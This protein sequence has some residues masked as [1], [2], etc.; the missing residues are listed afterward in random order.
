MHTP[1]PLMIESDSAW[2][3]RSI[4]KNE[5]VMFSESTKGDS[6]AFQLYVGDKEKR[7]ALYERLKGAAWAEKLAR[8]EAREKGVQREPISLSDKIKVTKFTT[9]ILVILSMP[10]WLNALSFNHDSFLPFYLVLAFSLIGLYF[11]CSDNDKLISNLNKVGVTV[12]TTSLSVG[13][14]G[15]SFILHVIMERL[16]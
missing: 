12:F 7:E 2:I 5:N 8:T 6:V 4:L 1:E 11:T 10:A 16:G 3:I 14:L 15:V 9:L 13:M